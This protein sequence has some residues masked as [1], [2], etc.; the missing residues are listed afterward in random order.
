MIEALQP[1]LALLDEGIVLYRRH[2]VAFL[3]IAASWVVPVAIAI[4][5]LVGVA[6]FVSEG[7]VVVLGF[8]AFLLLFPLFIYLVGGLS[9][10]AVAA[11]REGRVSFR[12]SLAI[13]PVR[14]AGMGCFTLLYTMVAQMVS[15]VVSMACICPLY[16]VGL[17]AIGG[18]AELAQEWQLLQTLGLAA[19]ALILVGVYVFVLI[20]GGAT[21]SS[22]I[23]ALQP[24]VQESGSFGVSIQRSFD[25]IGYRFW[26]NLATWGLAAVLVVAVGAIVMCTIGVLL[27]LPLSFALG[28]EVPLVQAISVGAW[29]MGLVLVL[30]PLPIWM[31]L[32]YQ[33]NQAVRDGVALGARIQD[34]CRDQGGVVVQAADGAVGVPSMMAG[35]SFDAE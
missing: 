13:S 30:P 28:A 33:R 34:W 21:Y 3:L 27:P 31:A 25:L 15:S 19:V 9:R 6:T 2:F 22:V 16:V 1:I 18:L 5:G 26:R 14:A 24:W 10:G 17:F 23:Y 12:E 11:I 7:W 32:L 4:G 8:S 29:V 20:V 35:G